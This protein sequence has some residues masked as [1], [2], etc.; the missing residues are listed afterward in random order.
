MKVLFIDDEQMLRTLGERILKK[1]G[2]EVVTAESGKEGI[3]A[4]SASPDTFDLIIIDQSMH[5]LSGIET[6][7][8]LR[9][10][11]PEIPFILS[12]GHQLDD[13]NVPSELLNNKRFLSKPYRSNQLV[14]MVEEVLAIHTH[15]D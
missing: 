13:Q 8:E 4:F 1:A 3:E 7:Q 5:G 14:E 15:Q 6:M 2:Y 10:K 12:S 9:R 11:K